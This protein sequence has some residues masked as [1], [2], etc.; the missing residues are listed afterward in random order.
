MFIFNNN[1]NTTKVIFFSRSIDKVKK[2]F[3]RSIVRQLLINLN[4]V[5]YLY[6]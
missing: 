5:R 3:C 6:Q 2:T 1:A 4:E